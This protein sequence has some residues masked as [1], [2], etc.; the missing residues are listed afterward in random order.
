MHENPIK[1]I[2]NIPIVNNTVKRRIDEMGQDVE[3]QLIK[4][5]QATE[6]ALQLDESTLPDNQALLMA[7][8][9]YMNSGVTHEEMLFAKTLKTDTKGRLFLIW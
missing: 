7:Y 4:M 5:I 3:L 1:F 6:F 9:R 2:Q 8:V